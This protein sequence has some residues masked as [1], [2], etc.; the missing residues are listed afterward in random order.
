MKSMD[1]SKLTARFRRRTDRLPAASQENTTKPEVAAA[2]SLPEAASALG[3]AQSKA[4]STAEAEPATT[5]ATSQVDAKTPA[6]PPSRLVEGARSRPA[7]PAEASAAMTK[8]AAALRGARPAAPLAA[9]IVLALGIGLGIG[10]AIRPGGSDSA[11][12]AGV[13]SAA[14][15]VRQSSHDI[16]L[17]AAELR[18]VRASVDGLKGDRDKSRGEILA[19]QAQLS[20]KLERNGQDQTARLARLSDQIERA[21]KSQRDSSRSQAS[22]EKLDR[23]EKVMPAGASAPTPP[24]KPVASAA[25]TPDVTHTGSIPDARP[26][27]KPDFDP[28]KTQVE[29]YFVRD[30]DDGYALLETRSGRYTEVTVG[31]TVPGLGRVE[32]IERRG[33]QWVVITAKGFIPER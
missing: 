24:P 3:S 27:A 14:A 31:H 10:A 32:A 29:G 17:L 1:T 25:A 30:V 15:E 8:L 33:R 4:S 6:V 2:E 12:T 21:E 26:T 11:A 9:A 22:T 16:A 28:R 7:E 5:A 13:L 23:I 20:D 19:K 18:G